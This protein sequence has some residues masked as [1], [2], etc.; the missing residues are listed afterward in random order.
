M[1]PFP[2]NRGSRSRYSPTPVWRWGMSPRADLTAF[3]P[4]QTDIVINADRPRVFFVGGP[5]R[6]QIG[7]QRVVAVHAAARNVQFVRLFFICYRYMLYCEPVVGCQSVRHLFFVRPVLRPDTGGKHGRKRMPWLRVFAGVCVPCMRRRRRRSLRSGTDRTTLPWA[8]LYR[9]RGRSLS[10]PHP[11]RKAVRMRRQPCRRHTHRSEML[12]GL[13]RPRAE[14]A[15]DNVLS[16]CFMV[17]RG[18]G[19]RP[20]HNGRPHDM[21][22]TA[23]TNR[24]GNLIC[25]FYFYNRNIERIVGMRVAVRCDN[26]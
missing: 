8:V 25:C 9:Q 23:S 7:A 20:G 6:A 15:R 11:Q 3:G 24:A 5:P 4:A 17:I 2:A 26:V 18:S 21:P 16:C 19:E 22:G 10:A 13:P 1:T 14:G 12:C